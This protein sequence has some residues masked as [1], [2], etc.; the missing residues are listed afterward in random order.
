MTDAILTETLAV[1]RQRAPDF[2][3]DMGIILG[4]GAGKFAQTMQNP[5]T[6]PYGD[7]PS[8]RKSG[9]EGHPGVLQ[10][11]SIQ[12]HSVACFN[13]RNHLYEGHPAAVVTAPIRLLKHLGAT[14]VILVVAVGSLHTDIPP[15]S[16]VMI[17]DHINFQF[18]NPLVGPNDDTLG[19]RFPS[20]EVAYN[21][22]LRSQL[23]D[24]AQ[25]LNMPIFEG[26]YIACL[27][28]S[29]ETPAE[30]RAFKQLGADVVGMS[31]V[32]EVI[33]ARHCGLEVLAVG[34]VTN[35]AVGLSSETVN[36]HLTL[37]T[38]AQTVDNLTQLLLHFLGRTHDA[39]KYPD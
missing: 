3:A 10:L 18:S 23:A 11:G 12:Q 7:L 8:L 38:A 34:L 37:A 29:F 24:C 25:Q 27:G 22:R 5:I 35:L 13:G 30:I 31:L 36:H 26:V 16:L 6:F 2:K 19:V 17:N 14:W 20:L 4:S 15:G 33:A 9:V 32:P 1:I 21:P 39:G 28:P